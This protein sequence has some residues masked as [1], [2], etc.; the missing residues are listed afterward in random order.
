M[1]GKNSSLDWDLVKRSTFTTFQDAV[2]GTC[3]CTELWAPD[4]DTRVTLDYDTSNL[5][6]KAAVVCGVMKVGIGL[7]R[8]DGEVS[9]WFW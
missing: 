3:G 2:Y 9:I 6:L 1:L 4:T 7:L 8:N 5:V